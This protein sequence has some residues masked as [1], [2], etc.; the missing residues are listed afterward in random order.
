MTTLHAQPRARRA[1]ACNGR[2]RSVSRGAGASLL[3]AL[4]AGC[5]PFPRTQPPQSWAYAAW[6]LP[7][8]QEGIVASGFDRLVYFDVSLASDGTIADAYGWPEAQAPLRDS[9]KR[10]GIPLDVAIALHGR[11]PLSTLFSSPQAVERLLQ[12]CL[13]LADDPAV[14]GLQLDF[15]VHEAMPPEALR[16][17][18]GFVP[19]L[20]RAL[21]ARHPRLALS[22]FVPVSRDPLYDRASLDKVDWVVMQGYDAHWT[23]STSAGPVAPLHGPEAVAWENVAAH[24]RALGLRRSRTLIGFPLYGYEWPVA[25]RDPRADTLA[26][27]VSRPLEPVAGSSAIGS[28]SVRKRVNLYGCQRDAA[29]ASNYY[30]FLDPQQGWITGWYESDWSLR[31]KAAFVREHRLAGLAFFAAGGDGYRLTRTY[32][33]WRKATPETPV[34]EPAPC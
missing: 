7:V 9:A 2:R 18:R 14:A 8:D 25:S 29:S 24:A 19:A 16:G 28:D 22:V 6:W 32:D 3:A 30:Q 12:T 15:E 20:R 31:R 11:E 17:L 23:G 4:L 34:A 13:E 21:S 27:G 26:A 5:V 10:L 1:R 33:A